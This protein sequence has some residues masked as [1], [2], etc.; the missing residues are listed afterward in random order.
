VFVGGSLGALRL[1]ELALACARDPQRTYQ[2]VHVCGPGYHADL[3]AELGDERPPDY[4]LRDYEDQMALAYAA[5][6]LVVCRAG[7][8]TLAELCAVGRGSLL[9]PSPNVT[10]NH[11]EGN[12]RSLETL[13]AAVVVPEREWDEVAVVAEVRS[14]L[15][16]PERLKAMGEAARANAKLDAAERAADLVETV[17]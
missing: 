9:I 6:D 2:L 5:A 4:H 10:E 13:G 7:S 1:N 3:V 11:Q 12:A 14:L 8:A 17:L 15:D 16:D